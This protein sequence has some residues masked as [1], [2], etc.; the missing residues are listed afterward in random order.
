M[1][2]AYVGRRPLSDDKLGYLYYEVTTDGEVH[3]ERRHFYNTLLLKCP[4]GSLISVEGD[5]EQIKLTG[6]TYVGPLGREVSAEWQVLDQA[7]NLQ[8]EANKKARRRDL[9]DAVRESLVPIRRAMA[10]TSPAGREAIRLLVLREL[11]R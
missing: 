10:K 3:E 9:V 7:N 4:P 11:G 5:G 8:Y 1:N 6:V 2:L